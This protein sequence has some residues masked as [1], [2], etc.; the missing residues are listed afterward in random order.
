MLAAVTALIGIAGHDEGRLGPRFLA[1][2]RVGRFDEPV[3]LAQPP[4]GDQL[5][6]VEKPGRIVVV[7]R[8][9]QLP[10]PFLDI[11]PRVKDTGEGG[12]QGLLSLAFAPDYPE[13]GLFYVSYTDRHDALR[14]VEY[15]R[16]QDSELR[17]ERR[18]ARNV[19]TIPQ[20]TTKHNGGLLLFGPDTLLYVGV[21]DGGPSGDPDGVAQDLSNLHGDRKSVV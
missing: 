8:G 21:G 7:D 13:S 16:S 9:R 4:R 19:L 15:R 3:Y 12:E 2:E 14:L 10:R 11:R 1:L 5:F 18:S 20:P 6:V 17:A